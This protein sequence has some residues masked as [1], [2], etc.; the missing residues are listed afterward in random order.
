IEASQVFIIMDMKASI[1]GNIGEMM[2]YLGEL[3]VAVATLRQS[4]HIYEQLAS[5]SSTDLRGSGDMRAK[6]GISSSLAKALCIQRKFEEGMGVFRDSIFEESR[7]VGEYHHNLAGKY[8]NAGICALQGGL[9]RE[10][11]EL[12]RKALTTVERNPHVSMQDT[13]DIAQSNLMRLDAIITDHHH[14]T[15]GGRKVEAEL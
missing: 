4:L 3:D 9:Y 14:Q 7:H 1:L 2:T 8:T 5:T 12:M 10:A 13:K 11:R 6:L 15:S